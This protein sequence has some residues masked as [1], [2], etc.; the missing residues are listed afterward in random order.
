MIKILLV[1]S[2]IVLILVSGCNKTV[3]IER[4]K[5]I[6]LETD[7]VFSQL[8]VEKGRVEAFGTYLAENA[9]TYATGQKPIIGKKVILEGM[10]KN[11][12]GTLQWEPFLIEMSSSGDLGYTL[13]N[14]TFTVKDKDGKES[15]SY[16]SYISVWKKQP[17]GMWKIVHDSGVDGPEEKVE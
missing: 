15:K 7:R 11:P 14:W 13:G 6:L 17:D 8:S 5:E 16:G 3:D 9:T 12:G 10:S 1:V 2:F 4:E